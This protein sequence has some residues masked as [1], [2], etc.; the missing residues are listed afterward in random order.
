[1]SA[2]IRIAGLAGVAAVAALA[3]LTQH[4]KPGAAPTLAPARSIDKPSPQEPTIDESMAAWAQYANPGEHHKHL[5]PLI[6][7]WNAA[8]RF[9]MDGP[10]QPPQESAAVATNTWVLG[11]RF[12]QQQ[13]RGSLLDQAFEGLGYWGYDNVSQKHISLWMDT[14]LTGVL[15]QAG[16]CD[17]SGRTFTL[18]GSFFDP[19]TNTTV[20][21]RSVLTIQ[22][23]NTFTYEM[24]HTTAGNREEKV[25]EIVYTRAR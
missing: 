5:E 12:V 18:S 25:G 20:K 19:A 23:N 11:G 8:C 7:T 4:E 3:A 24:F 17:A 14:M 9:Y 10:D 6:G 22:D 1:M 16:S 21:D 15:H 13:F 2:R